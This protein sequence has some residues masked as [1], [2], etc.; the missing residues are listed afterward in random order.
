M[1]LVKGSRH[2]CGD[3]YCNKIATWSHPVHGFR[4]DDHVGWGRGYVLPGW[5][6]LL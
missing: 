1:K 3:P 5:E 6:A 2:K 4:C